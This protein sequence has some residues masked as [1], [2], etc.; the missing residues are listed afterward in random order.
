MSKL[1]LL[2]QIYWKA[3]NALGRIAGFGFVA[4]GLGMGGWSSFLLVNSKATVNWN[5]EHTAD[6]GPKLVILVMSLL[7]IGMGIVLIK[8]KPS[9][10]YQGS[11]KKG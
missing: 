2:R 11:D 5:G 1:K 8:A 7:L 3:F 9:Q 10:S 4:V 6:V